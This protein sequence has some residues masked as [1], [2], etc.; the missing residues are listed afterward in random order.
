MQNDTIIIDGYKFNVVAETAY[1]LDEK[2]GTLKQTLF[3]K[4]ENQFFYDNISKKIKTDAHILIL[5]DNIQYNI[6]NQVFIRTDSDIITLEIIKI[7]S[8]K[9]REKIE[10]IT[11]IQNQKISKT[12]Q[13][14][15]EEKIK[16]LEI[17]NK[18]HSAK[19]R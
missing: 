13:E 11:T 7:L 16:L 3:I 15:L 2:Y 19:N 17:K 10:K 4:D 6:I 5:F 8:K 9:Q 14:A 1:Y 12:K 18:C